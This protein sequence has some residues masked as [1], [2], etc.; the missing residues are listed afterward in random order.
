MEA[1]QLSPSNAELPNGGVEI[2][3]SDTGVGVD[4]DS[5]EIIFSK[6]YQPGELLQTFHQ[7]DALQGQRRRAGAG[8]FQRHCRG[9]RRAHLGGKQGLR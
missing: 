1:Q 8:A 2:V 7:Q 6:F 3:V 5:R 4:P 9:A